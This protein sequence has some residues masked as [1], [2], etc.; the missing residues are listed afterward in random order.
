MAADV[1]STDCTLAF[2]LLSRI[3][4]G[5]KPLLEIYERFIT[6]TGKG[7]IARMSAQLLKVC[8]SFALPDPA[9]G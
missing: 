2:G 3:P 7:M 8:S 9:L 4:D 1:C 6:S 5:V